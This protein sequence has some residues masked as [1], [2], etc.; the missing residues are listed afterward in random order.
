[1]ISRLYNL[2]FDVPD[3]GLSRRHP[4]E[5]GK[6]DR[7]VAPS[8]YPDMTSWSA[9]PWPADPV[10]RAEDLFSEGP[11]VGASIDFGMERRE[12]SDIACRCHVPSLP[13][14]PPSGISGFPGSTWST[15]SK[16]KI[17]PATGGLRGLLLL[18]A[19]NLCL[20]HLFSVFRRLGETF[21]PNSWACGAEMR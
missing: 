6:G 19:T 17:G 1:V 15:P 8:Y 4:V 18:N 20:S 3:K 5:W 21:S 10:Q 14:Q 11:N 2:E 9:L 13:G 16:F 7:V 12:G